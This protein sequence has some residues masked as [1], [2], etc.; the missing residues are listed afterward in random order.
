MGTNALGEAT[1]LCDHIN[2]TEHFANRQDFVAR[3]VVLH[4]CILGTPVG[5]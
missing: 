3:L 1:F 2:Y 4:Y 5:T